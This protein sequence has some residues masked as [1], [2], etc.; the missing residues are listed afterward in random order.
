ML[1]MRMSAI[2]NVDPNGVQWDVL[3]P[4]AIVKIV[5]AIQPIKGQ[6]SLNKSYNI[7]LN[8]ILYEEFF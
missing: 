3:S 2:V 5:N 6:E 4:D 8:Q 7:T 1:T